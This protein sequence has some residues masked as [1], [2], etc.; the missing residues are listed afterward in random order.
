MTA[1]LNGPLWYVA[2]I[3]YRRFDGTEVRDRKLVVRIAAIAARAAESAMVLETTHPSHRG[4][5]NL[6]WWTLVS[7]KHT[8]ANKRARK[9]TYFSGNSANQTMCATN[10]SPTKA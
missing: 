8:Y 9:H 10:R 3:I 4:I 1:G 2:L 6:N 7:S 5:I